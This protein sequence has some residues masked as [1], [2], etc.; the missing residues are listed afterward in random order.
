[1]VGG[2]LADGLDEDGEVLRVLAVPRLEGGEELEAV[3]LGVDDDVD[4]RA[5]LGRRRVRVLAGVVA[6]RRELLAGRV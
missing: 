1:V 3:R 6:A 2:A 5:V 4:R